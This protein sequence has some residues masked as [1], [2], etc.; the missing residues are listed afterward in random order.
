[1]TCDFSFSQ[2]HD[3]LKTMRSTDGAV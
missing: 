1:M 2:L 3:A